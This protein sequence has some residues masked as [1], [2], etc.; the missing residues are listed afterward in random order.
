[1]GK[2]GWLCLWHNTTSP[3]HEGEPMGTTRR[4]N[5]RWARSCRK[6]VLTKGVTNRCM[7]WLSILFYTSFHLLH[8]QHIFPFKN[9]LVPLVCKAGTTHGGSSMP[10]KTRFSWMLQVRRLVAQRLLIHLPTLLLP[11]HSADDGPVAF[12]CQGS[13]TLHISQNVC[14]EGLAKTGHSLGGQIERLLLPRALIRVPVTMSR[15]R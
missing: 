3:P 1:M 6:D 15:R 10:C 4:A 13:P 14:S 12:L 5:T 8:T 11:C 7:Q 9:Y 2:L